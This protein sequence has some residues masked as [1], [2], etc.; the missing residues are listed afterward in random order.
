[1]KPANHLERRT[2]ICRGYYPKVALWLTEHGDIEYW[3]INRRYRPMARFRSD[4]VLRATKSEAQL[5]APTTV[6]VNRPAPALVG[7]LFFTHLDRRPF[8]YFSDRTLATET[9]SDIFRAAPRLPAVVCRERLYLNARVPA[10]YADASN[11]L[12]EFASAENVSVLDASDA[13]AA[14]VLTPELSINITKR[15]PAIFVHRLET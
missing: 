2:K 10:E 11:T 7:V 6:T 8:F 3:G 4:L 13:V 5:V 12:R 15:Y 1:M 14:P 9:V